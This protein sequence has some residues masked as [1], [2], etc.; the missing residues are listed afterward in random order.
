MRCVDWDSNDQTESSEHFSSYIWAGWTKKEAQPMQVDQD[1][2]D[3]LTGPNRGS[4]S[5]SAS[6]QPATYKVV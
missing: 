3:M 4:A 6:S 5:A 1:I 2:L